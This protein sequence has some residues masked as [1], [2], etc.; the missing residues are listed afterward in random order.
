MSRMT[1][2]ALLLTASSLTMAEPVPHGTLSDVSREGQVSLKGQKL[3]YR[4]AHSRLPLL[5][6]SGREIAKITAISYV[7][8]DT[9]SAANRP[10]IFIWDGGPGA[11]GWDMVLAFL[12]P[13]LLHV[14]PEMGTY[15]V[16]DNP[17]TLLDIADIVAIDPVGSGA[18]TLTDPEAGKAFLGVQ[19]DAAAVS[20]FIDTWLK[21]QGR[22]SAPVYLAG[23]SYGGFRVAKVAPLLARHNLSGLI[24]LS[25]GLNLS[26]FRGDVSQVTG[27]PRWTGG[28]DDDQAFVN[29][30]PTYAATA[31]YHGR[32]TSGAKSVEAAYEEAR[33][34][35]E[36]DLLV[37]LR[38]GSALSAEDR[39]RLAGRMAPMIGM[40]MDM[41]ANANLRVQSQPFLD[42]LVKNG[43]T[44]RLDS[45]V[46]ASAA[47]P[48]EGSGAK[49]HAERPK[50]FDD[51]SPSPVRNSEGQSKA[52]E[53]YLAKTLGSPVGH[54]Q[55]NPIAV[56]VQW[57]WNS[58]SPTL[59]AN[60]IGV[61]AAP[62][63]AQVMRDRPGV[64]LFLASGYYDLAVVALDQRRM[65]DHLGIAAERSDRHFYPSGHVLQGDPETRPVLLRDL[66][67]FMTGAPAG[68]R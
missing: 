65:L 16:S 48:A 63:L 51:P 31:F 58:H 39:T 33:Q 67:T 14:E 41:I 42:N 57:D 46:V 22:E 26:A 61:N 18:S 45:R 25:P 52:V 35:A 5:D 23:S 55:I 56:N 50:S 32:N 62:D 54:Y 17:D 27:D 37:A 21:E 24:L 49:G 8:T 38:Q 34:F 9:G 13:K 3:P 15:K 19:G 60:I 64:R 1:L 10:V 7:R 40:P 2:A 59:E 20:T 44:G 43:V 53:A 36:T 30:L 47:D 6:Q 28:V 11:A 29:S 66:R 12:G 68:V 4:F